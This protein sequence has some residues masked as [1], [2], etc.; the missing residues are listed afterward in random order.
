MGNPVIEQILDENSNL[1][2]QVLEAQ[3]NEF[4]N[5]FEPTFV[6]AEQTSPTQE[7][8]VKP[9]TVVAPTDDSDYEVIVPK[10][11]DNDPAESVKSEKKEHNDSVVFDKP[12]EDVEQPQTPP[13]VTPEAEEQPSETEPTK[14]EKP[15][16]D[17]PVTDT[18][19][20]DIPSQPSHDDEVVVPEVDP[21]YKEPVVDVI[22]GKNSESPQFGVLGKMVSNGRVIGMDLNE[23]NTI[24]LFGV[25][26]AGKSYR[27]VL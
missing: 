21:N 6:P 23:C 5:F 17:V 8:P 18:P 13:A 12:K 27:L 24:S 4:V 19:V 3:D 14:E 9:V 10:K 15:E 11:V 2:T 25:Q 22:I 16:K 26:G 7:S 1:K 20:E